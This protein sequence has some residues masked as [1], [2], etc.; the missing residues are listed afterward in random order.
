MG[1]CSGLTRS[2]PRWVPP[3]SAV[4]ACLRDLGCEEGGSGR[5]GLGKRA[6]RRKSELYSTRSCQGRISSPSTKVTL[7]CF[8]KHRSK[9]RDG[10]YER[11]YLLNTYVLGPSLKGKKWL[12]LRWL[13]PTGSVSPPAP[14][15][16]RLLS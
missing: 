10:F 5:A 11:L 9:P 7:T 6:M 1:L 15:P 4:P 8:P 13:V 2:S 3:A 16:C 14:P 12:L